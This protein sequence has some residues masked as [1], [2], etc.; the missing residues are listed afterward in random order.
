MSRV[1]ETTL[2]KKNAPIQSGR[3][4]SISYSVA[5]NSTSGLRRF[6]RCLRRGARGRIHEILQFLAWLEEGNLLCRHF[7]LFAGLRISSHAPAALPCAEA[8]KSANFDFVA[9][10]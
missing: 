5:K 6:A 8:A 9:L 4:A 2:P 10:L 7:H 1:S 3:P